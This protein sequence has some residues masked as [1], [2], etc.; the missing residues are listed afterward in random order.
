MINPKLA[1][2]YPPI[3]WGQTAE[4]VAGGYGITGEAEE[5]WALG[6]H[7]KAVAAQE[8]C[9]FRNEMVAVALA[10]GVKIEKDE[11][12]RRD[13]SLE[14]L[15]S[16]KPAFAK[17]GTLTGGNSSPPPDGAACLGFVAA[18]PA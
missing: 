13:T 17:D 14:K 18:R 16:L 8:A 5:E 1:E 15:A 10:D 12:P 3:S 11:G 9:H 7:R 2:R 6:S 4:V